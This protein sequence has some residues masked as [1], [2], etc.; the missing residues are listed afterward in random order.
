MCA[1]I[2]CLSQYLGTGSVM[3]QG[4]SHILYQRANQLYYCERQ[5]YVYLCDTDAAKV[6][7]WFRQ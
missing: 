2:A 4:Q 3:Y 7:Y 1:S 6:R 5:D